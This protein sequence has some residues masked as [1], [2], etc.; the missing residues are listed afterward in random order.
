MMK[1][2]LERTEPLCEGPSLNDEMESSE[3][4]G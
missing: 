3:T 2:D 1:V 4:V